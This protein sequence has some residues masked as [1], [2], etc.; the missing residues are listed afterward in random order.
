MKGTRMTLHKYFSIGFVLLACVAM[1][2][3]PTVHASMPTWS[4]GSSI[5]APPEKLV[6]VTDWDGVAKRHWAGPTIWGNRTQDWINENGKLECVVADDKL[7][8]RTAHLLTYDLSAKSGAF[9][10]SV[11][12][13]V[14]AG[15][16]L[17]GFAGFLIGAGEGRLDYR[18]ASMIHHYPG[19]GGGILTV[20]Q[21][22]RK[23]GLGFLDMGNNETLQ[24]LRIKGQKTILANPFNPRNVAMRIVLQ[25]V[26]S[27]D[28]VYDLHLTVRDNGTGKLLGAQELTGIPEFRL[29]G[30]VALVASPPGPDVCYVFE[31]FKI[32]GEKFDHHPDREFG[33]IAGTLYSLSDDTL[34]LGAQFMSIGVASTASPDSATIRPRLSAT[35]RAR[36]KGSKNEWTNV[37]G[38]NAVQPPDYYVLFRVT[39]WD[40]TKDWETQ[41][42]FKD[43]RGKMYTYDTT[44]QHDPTDKDVVSLAAFTGMGVMGHTATDDLLNPPE[45]HFGMGRWAPANLWMPFE[46][47]VKNL[48]NQ[49]VDMLFF[50]G[51]QIYEHKPST[52]AREG[53][54]PF[55]D[56]LYKWIMWHWSF[57]EL[58]NHLPA[59]CQPDDHDI[60][61]GNFWG[62]GGRRNLTGHPGGK[63]GG[64]L[65][66]PS[67]VN[68]V[69]HTQTGHHPDA[70]DAG[71]ADSGIM[72]YYSAAT[73]GD[74][75]FAILEDRKFK[76]PGNLRD[77][78][79]QTQ[80][81]P[82]QLQFLEEWGEDW[83]DQKFKIVASQTLYA[84]VH[85]N[86]DG[87]LASDTD[88]N[89][90]PK[91]GRDRSVNMFRRCGA[92]VICGDL[93]LASF[94]R[95]GIDKPSDAVYQFCVPPMGNVFW[96]WFYTAEPGK[97]R[98]PGD[99]EYYGEHVDPHGNM[100]RMLAVANPEK[101]E[102]LGNKLRRRNLIPEAEMVEGKGDSVRSCQG[103]G[104]GIVRL[105]KK[106]RTITSECWPYTS[107]PTAGGKQFTGWPVTVAFED[108]DGREAVAWL[109]DLNIEGDDDP[110]VQIIDK[111][112]G[113]MIKITR[114]HDRFY[115]P[116]VFDADTVYTLR[117]GVPENS[118]PWWEATDLKPSPKAGEKS[119]EV[120]FEW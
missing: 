104:Y 62:D 57:R 76:S 20:L 28:D 23:V 87:T 84:S 53:Y 61:Q 70:Y 101:E 27:G 98:N 37:A 82:R 31:D 35:L 102:L 103:D 22:A 54:S 116:G 43:E 44:I 115:R 100:F 13:T 8:C 10:M 112:T 94:T 97:G 107:D 88:S 25:A 50:T 33:P 5:T 21:P 65:Y 64:Y 58:T 9:E 6:E 56:Y 63:G 48:K 51:D 18:S 45:G 52:A 71:P 26:P 59:F 111:K 60:Y 73:Y 14:P 39:D 89:G 40:S 41:V 7:P 74:T 80:L 99:P 36:H 1:A 106:E 96:R 69:H 93:H 3:G 67:F 46:E 77:K 92:Y 12:L 16:K 105:D 17:G 113:E 79:K 55:T 117:V 38:P 47:A 108:L 24:Y 29:R 66:S 120:S 68:V 119:L 15:S 34:K 110:V 4:D 83:K 114:A 2:G 91:V 72:H 81:G 49:D 11:V 95:L 90:W 19:R 32:S 118:G 86:F 30:N 42:V 85:V 78:K 75:G 109:P